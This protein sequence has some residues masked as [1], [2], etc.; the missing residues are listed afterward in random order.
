MFEALIQKEAKLAV[1]G[2]GYV[3]LP[4][5]ME[6]AKRFSVV[7]YDINEERLA[8]MRRGEDPCGELPSEAF[9]GGDILFTSDKSRV[10]EALFFVIAVPTPID[11]HNEPDLNPLLGATRTVAAC[12]KQGDYV[13]LESTV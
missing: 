2:L 3:G 12:L 10:A 1:V 4:L 7:G 6:F 9:V 8:A 11:S 13:V 5:A